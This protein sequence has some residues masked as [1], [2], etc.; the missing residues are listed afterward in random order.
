MTMADIKT[1]VDSFDLPDVDR[2]K[3]TVLSSSTYQQVP[4]YGIKFST[5]A[6]GQV[7]RLESVDSFTLYGNATYINYDMYMHYNGYF[8]FCVF[9]PA[10]QEEF[11]FEINGIHTLTSGDVVSTTDDTLKAKG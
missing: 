9:D 7:S 10:N 8:N 5:S 6:R 4:P 11:G 3:W 1:L 2:S